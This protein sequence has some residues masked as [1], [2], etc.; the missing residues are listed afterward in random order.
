MERNNHR[1]YLLLMLTICI[2]YLGCSQAEKTIIPEDVG[3]SSER[4]ER[5]A[6]VVQKAI[7]EEKITGVVTLV[8]RKGEIV[9][10]KS[11]GMMDK[12][13]EK[14]MQTDAIFRLCSMT[15]PITSV[16]VM[17]LY[18]EGHFMLNEPVSKFI[19][20]FKDMKVLD[21]PFPED[22]TSPPQNLVKAKRPIT[23]YHLL[24]HTSGLSYHWNPRV[25]KMYTEK[26]IGT[27]AHQQEGTIGE[28]VKRLAEVPLLFHPGDE[29]HYGLSVDVLGYLIEVVSG[30]SLDDFFKER[31]FK[32]LGMNNTH[33]YLPD[34]KISRL[35]TP[36]S[37][38][39]EQ[40]LQ[41]FPKE[42]YAKGGLIVSADYPYRGPKTYFAGGGGLCSTAKDYYKFC[43]M[44][45]N[46]GELNGVRLL[47]RKS[48]ELIS[49]NHAED[50]L[51]GRGFGLGFGTYSEPSHLKELGS[52][53]AYRWAGLFYSSFIIDPRE[54]LITIFMSQL[55]PI[56]GLNLGIK[57]HGLA[58]QAIID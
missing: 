31:L 7:D 50:E 11:F 17:L 2:G 37:F 56:G 13:A 6:T 24:T 8:A 55:H 52:I 21:P 57:F 10:S 12:E 22:R 28:A 14:P 35:T 38:S 5:I 9:Y 4:L 48:V 15:K 16:A 34:E 44:M 39:Q 42:P 1:L 19:P 43:Q 27:G 36:Y 3:L 51:K 33:F 54:E 20:E 40:G 25:G 29:W 45:L 49:Q 58:Y 30:M 18:E 46:G 26:G 47:S 41:R 53:G 32:P 23:I